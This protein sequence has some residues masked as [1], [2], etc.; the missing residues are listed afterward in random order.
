[1]VFPLSW[2]MFYSL[3]GSS[4]H[5]SCFSG[6][7]CCNHAGH[8]ALHCPCIAKPRSI[9]CFW[10][11]LAL[12]SW[13]KPCCLSYLH[14]TWALA[15]ILT[16]V[17]AQILSLAQL[18]LLPIASVNFHPIVLTAIFS[19]QIKTL[20]KNQLFGHYHV[21]IYWIMLHLLWLTCLL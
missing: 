18:Y 14:A 10:P 4:I 21:V 6:K 20:N 2:L 12:F 11:I 7:R 19:P 9:P 16:M 13:P 8:H 5:S 3:L 15:H 17:L 1:M